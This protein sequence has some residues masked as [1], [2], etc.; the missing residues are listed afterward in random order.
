MKTNRIREILIL[1][2][3]PL[4]YLSKMPYVFRAW[5]NSPMDKLDWIALPAALLAAFHIFRNNKK[6]RLAD[7][8]VP[9]RLVPFG[10]ALALFAAAQIVS[11]N[12]L[13]LLAAVAVWWCSCFA[14]LTPALAFALL[15]SFL[16]L[17]L[18]CTS[19]TY[20]LGYLLSLPTPMVL[21]IKGLAAA[22]IL[23]LAAFRI[24]IK[25]ELL[26]FMG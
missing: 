7:P 5:H 8:F 15:P 16:L 11:I 25:P 14:A 2:V 20:W 6:Q 4:C 18:G 17:C 21:G 10:V 19:S 22:G 3:G 12:T 23:L 1:A 24:T 9:V 26:A 13:A